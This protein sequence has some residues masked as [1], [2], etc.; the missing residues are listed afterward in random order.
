MVTNVSSSSACESLDFSNSDWT[1]A[2]YMSRVDKIRA[3]LD[4]GQPLPIGMSKKKE[5]K[6]KRQTRNYFQSIVFFDCHF[7]SEQ[8]ECVNGNQ[9]DDSG[10][11]TLLLLFSTPNSQQQHMPSTFVHRLGTISYRIETTFEVR[12][13]S[14]ALCVADTS[15]STTEPMPSTG[16]PTSVWTTKEAGA[17]VLS[18]L[19]LKLTPETAGSTSKHPA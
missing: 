13:R 16:Q 11:G 19:L 1:T 12:V 2:Y 7:T 14:Q 6:Q 17:C 5:E 8:S 15:I 18:A 4:H 3:I 10:P 9:K